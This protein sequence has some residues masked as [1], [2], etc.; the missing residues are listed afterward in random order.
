MYC[1]YH[2]YYYY[3]HYQY[4]DYYYYY[5]LY[6]YCH[7]PTFLAVLRP[8]VYNYQCVGLLGDHRCCFD[9]LELCAKHLRNTHRRWTE[10]W[11]IL[12]VSEWLPSGK[13]TELWEITIFNGKISYFYGYFQ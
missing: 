12:Q 4:H 6:C 10:E 3:Y 8:Q 9:H 7:I 11:G 1:Y 5:H 13:L 2:Y